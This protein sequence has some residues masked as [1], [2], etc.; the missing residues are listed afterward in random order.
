VFETIMMMT[1]DLFLDKRK[2]REKKEK[3]KH[4][5]CHY[6]ENSLIVYLIMQTKRQCMVSAK[7]QARFFS[8]LV[9][10]IEYCLLDETKN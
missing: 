10:S 7:P 1:N 4:I 2:D 9:V 8:Y 5:K 3:A 6:L